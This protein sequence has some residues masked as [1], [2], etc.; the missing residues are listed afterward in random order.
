MKNFLLTSIDKIPK[1][2]HFA[3]IEF[4]KITIPGDA[5]SRTHPGH[6]YPESIERYTRYYAYFDE[7]EWLN[8][9]R[10]R[11]NYKDTNFFAIKANP[12]EIT[13]EVVVKVK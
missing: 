13:T 8:E 4:S 11:I 3:I 12:V 10:E 6:G 1:E 2:P 5:R 9:I 7:A